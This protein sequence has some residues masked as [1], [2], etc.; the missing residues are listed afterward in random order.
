MSISDRQSDPN[1][2]RNCDT[3][4]HGCPWAHIPTLD[5][6]CRITDKSPKSQLVNAVHYLL[7]ISGQCRAGL[8]PNLEGIPRYPAPLRTFACD[9]GYRAPPPPRAIIGLQLQKGDELCPPYWQISGLIWPA[10]ALATIANWRRCS[11]TTTLPFSTAS[12]RSRPSSRSSA[13]SRRTSAASST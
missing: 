8:P 4:T 13:T 12:R 11:P 2:E 5:T 7:A 3:R 10:P 9:R 6:D 1:D